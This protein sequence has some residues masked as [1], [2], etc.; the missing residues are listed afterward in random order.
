MNDT[1]AHLENSTKPHR[2]VKPPSVAWCRLSFTQKSTDVKLSTPFSRT[3]FG[4]KIYGWGTMNF[5]L[6]RDPYCWAAPGRSKTC[7]QTQL[8]LNKI[9]RIQNN[10]VPGNLCGG[11]SRALPVLS[12]VSDLGCLI[13]L[14]LFYHCQSAKLKSTMSKAPPG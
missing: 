14:W 12:Q 2:T 7:G 8:S 13:T 11:P 5:R 1:L 9:S 4:R 6:F 10:D 3:L